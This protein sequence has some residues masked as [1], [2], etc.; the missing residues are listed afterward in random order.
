MTY[1]FFK[2]K[3]VDY[4]YI[5]IRDEILSDIDNSK[6]L[7]WGFNNMLCGKMRTNHFN[8]VFAIV[9]KFFEIIEPTYVFLERKIINKL[10]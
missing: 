9:K 5:P 3:K 8:G 6:Q 2:K 7:P 1:L 4:L 10:F